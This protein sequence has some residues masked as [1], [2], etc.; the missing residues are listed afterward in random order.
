GGSGPSSGGSTAVGSC[1]RT[2]GSCS[3]P[4]VRV[5]DITLN[6]A[7]VG[8][9]DEG[10][11]AP[12]PMA[13]ASTPSGQSRL[14]WLGKDGNVHV[15]LLDCDDHLVGTPFAFPAEDLQDLYADDKGGV[16]LL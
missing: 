13:L 3:A 7:M 6:S 12:L 10:D 1:A 16:V 11:T 9:G 15:G 14:A 4:T 2:A 8:Y 5:T